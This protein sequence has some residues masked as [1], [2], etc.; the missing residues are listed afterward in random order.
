MNILEVEVCTLT[1]NILEV[2]VCTLTIYV[3]RLYFYNMHRN[4]LNETKLTGNILWVDR[5]ALIF[6]LEACDRC[7]RGWPLT[8]DGATCYVCVSV[9][10]SLYYSFFT[11]SVHFADRNSSSADTRFR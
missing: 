5:T 10:T 2:E 3:G 1:V 4:H 11:R 6:F 8:N 9:Y 7:K